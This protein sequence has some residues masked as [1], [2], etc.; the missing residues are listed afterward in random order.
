MKDH[1]DQERNVRH[2]AFTIHPLYFLLFFCLILVKTI[3]Q[4]FLCDFEIF[5]YFLLLIFYNYLQYLY[6][7]T[8]LE[9]F[10]HFS[11]LEILFI[12]FFF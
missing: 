2:V 10:F 7:C 9:N 6:V 4:L 12:L 1:L 11:L 3:F 8:I 5:Y